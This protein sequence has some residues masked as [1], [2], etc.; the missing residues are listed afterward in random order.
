MITNPASEFSDQELSSLLRQFCHHNPGVG[1][2]MA[3]GFLQGRGY[4]VTKA[5]IHAVLRSRDPLSTVM[6]WPGGNTRR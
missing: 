2:S 4:R 1:E 6:K 3:S 5:R